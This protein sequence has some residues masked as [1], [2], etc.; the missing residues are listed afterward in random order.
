MGIPNCAARGRIWLVDRPNRLLARSLTGFVKLTRLN[1]LKISARISKEAPSDVNQGIL[2]ALLN[3]T[4]ALAN[5]G[6]LEGVPAQVALVSW[7]RHRE[8]GRRERTR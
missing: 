1:K 8:S 6:T 5:P 2:L 4:L 3:S 7:S